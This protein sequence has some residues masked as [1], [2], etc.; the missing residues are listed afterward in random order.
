LGAAFKDEAITKRHSD[1]ACALQ[2]LTNETLVQ[3]ARYAKKRTRADYLC[4]AGGVALN[5]T[6]NALLLEQ[7]LFK[8]VFIQPAANDAGASLG[9][10]LYLS[11]TGNGSTRPILNDAYLGPDQDG[12]EIEDVLSEFDG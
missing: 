12:R 10:A 6:A 9:S 4:I 7:N 11:L 8:G 1:I 2:S 3:L 5:C